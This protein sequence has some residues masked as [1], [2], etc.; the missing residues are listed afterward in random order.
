MQQST[1]VMR[2][3][4]IKE[5]MVTRGESTYVSFLDISSANTHLTDNG[6]YKLEKG[7][8]E[9][10]INAGDIVNVHATYIIE[11]EKI[12][13]VMINKITRYGMNA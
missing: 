8:I 6:W 1:R 12:T 9:P 7:K 5:K 10:E 2:Q 4:E 13:N 11:N 3:A